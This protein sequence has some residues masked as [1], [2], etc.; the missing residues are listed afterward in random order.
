MPDL[1]SL[2]RMV[3]FLSRPPLLGYKNLDICCQTRVRASEVGF[4]AL[5]DD[6][7]IRVEIDFSL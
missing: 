7:R 1:L 6:E 2:S 5:F 4:T 3:R